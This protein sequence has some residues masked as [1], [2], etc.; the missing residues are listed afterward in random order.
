MTAAESGLVGG[1][2]ALIVASCG[3]LLAISTARAAHSVHPVKTPACIYHHFA[4]AHDTAYF[5]IMLAVKDSVCAV[6][7]TITRP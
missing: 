2:S 5:E 6:T 3:L 7:I 1:L 4:T